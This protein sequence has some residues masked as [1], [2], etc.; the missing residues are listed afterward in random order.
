MLQSKGVGGFAGTGTA[1]EDRHRHWTGT[2]RLPGWRLLL[3]G[4]GKISPAARS[5]GACP[6]GVRAVEIRRF[7]LCPCCISE[8]TQRP[9][10]RAGVSM[11]LNESELAARSTRLNVAIP[12]SFPS[13]GG[14]QPSR[15]TRRK[16]RVDSED[17]VG[18]GFSQF[19]SASPRTS[20]FELG[21]IRKDTAWRS[22]FHP[23]PWIHSPGIP[24]SRVCDLQITELVSS[25]AG[26]PGWRCL[27]SLIISGL[28]RSLMHL[29][30]T[31]GITQQPG[32]SLGSHGGQSTREVG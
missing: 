20:L 32:S 26:K 17:K 24:S 7:P 14:R 9:P 1:T 16:D 10:S 11:T 27:G 29:L 22:G 23:W 2:G 13:K 25:N 31:D 18:L 3:F 8:A 4:N 19:A 21:P 30:V 15:P 6:V 5:L 28:R 12:N